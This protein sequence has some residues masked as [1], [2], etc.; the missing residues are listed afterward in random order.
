M[1]RFSLK[2]EKTKKV[3]IFLQKKFSSY[4][5]ITVD[6]SEKLKKLP[7]SRMTCD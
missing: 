7:Y 1:Q 6:Q 5:G 4:F 3:F 2:P